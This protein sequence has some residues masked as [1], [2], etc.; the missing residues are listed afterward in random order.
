MSATRV[1][2]TGAWGAAFALLLFG[3]T[4]LKASHDDKPDGGD[5]S[6]SQG[7][8]GTGGNRGDRDGGPSGHVD[9]DAGDDAGPG[10]EPS[11][12]SDSAD[13]PAAV[14]GGGLQLQCDADAS[15]CVA[16]GIVS[17]GADVTRAGSA[18]LPSGGI[19]TLSDDGFELGATTCD[20]SGK[21]CVTGGIAP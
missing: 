11:T 5:A 9:R 8:G 17:G 4:D 20:A 21:L 1:G 2:M 10:D 13:D 7:R 18:T 19:V 6:T 3:C 12:P 15:A 14:A 16:G